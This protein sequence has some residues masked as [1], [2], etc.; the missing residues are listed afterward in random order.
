V[1]RLAALGRGRMEQRFP[2]PW[3][4]PVARMREFVLALRAIWTSWETGAPLAH[5]GEFYRH[6]L[7]AP[8]FDP[9]PSGYG[10]PPV[11]LAAVG[12]AMTAIAGEVADGVLCHPLT[13]PAYFTSVMRPALERGRASAGARQDRARDDGFTVVASVLAATG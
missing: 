2:M 12:P 5:D 4:K 10:P 9:G 8:N 1:L 13:T 11:Y 7:M 6:T 3:S